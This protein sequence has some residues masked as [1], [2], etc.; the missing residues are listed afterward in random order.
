MRINQILLFFTVLPFV[1]IAQVSPPTIN[2]CDGN[3][4]ICL[5]MATHNLCVNLT[6]Q[7]GSPAINYF[8][9]DWGDGSTI[10][11]VPGSQT[12]ADQ[13]HPYNLINFYNKCD[14]EEKFTVEL[15]T[16]YV[17]DP[18]P[19]NNSFVVRF[20]NKPLPNF[21]YD[22]P[23]CRNVDI[24]INNTTCENA[25]TATYAWTF[26]DGT[27]STL[28][29]PPKSYS[30]TGTY[31]VQLCATNECGTNCITQT[32]MV[33]DR[34]NISNLT[35]TPQNGCVPF[36]SKFTANATGIS[37]NGYEWKV[38]S[39]PNNCTSCAQFIPATG[40]DSIMPIIRF[41]EPGP[42]IVQLIGT[43]SCGDDTVTITINAA[44]LPN[45]IFDPISAGC[46]SLTVN[47]DNQFIEYQGTI[48]SYQWTFPAG[49]SMAMSN[50]ATPG[51][52]IFTQSGTI[53]LELR[54]PCDTIFKTIP[55][56][57]NSQTAVSFSPIPTSICVS[58]PAFNLQATPLGGSFSGTGIINAATGLF[59]PAIAGVGPD[60]IIYKQGVPGCESQGS[61]IITIL[62]ADVVTIGGNIAVC[63]DEPPLILTANP[64]PGMWSG[65]GVSGNQFNPA[66]A[67]IG[68]NTI[69]YKYT[70][71]TG[72]VTNV[73]RVITVVAKPIITA[74][75]TIYTCK[76]N[77][78]VNLA[79]LG[80]IGFT[81][82]LPFAGSSVIWSGLGVTPTGQFTSPGV[83]NY[84]LMVNYTIPPLCDT[85]RTIIVKVADFV[86]AA[87]GKDT[88]LCSSSGTY[89]LGGQPAGGTW[90][91]A[92]GIVVSNPVMLTP[93]NYTFTYTIQQGTP[94][95]SRD[96][97]AITVVGGNAVNA[98]TDR[99][100]C[101]TA[102]TLTLP[103][104][105]GLNWTGPSLNG[106]TIDI[107][108]LNPG[109]YG[110]TLTD[111]S[112]PAGCNTDM[113][114][115]TVAMQPSG[116]FTT[117][118]TACVGQT[119]T[120]LP[121]ATANVQYQINWGDG[122][123]IGSA[124]TH[125]YN[126]AGPYTITF[127]VNTFQGA[128][129][130]CTNSSTAPIY[131]FPPPQAFDFS[132]STNEGC[133]PLSVNFTNSSIVEGGTFFWDF[134]NGQTYIG[135]SPGTIIFEQGIEDTTYQVRCVLKTRCDS[136]VLVKTV[137]VRP[138]PRAG[139]GFTYPFPCS[140][141]FIE[142]NLTSVG[143]PDT[144]T[145]RT[146]EGHVIPAKLGQPYFLQ[147]FTDSLPKTV[148]IWVI[149]ENFC[150]IDTAYQEVIVQPANVVALI[151]LNQ[152]ST[153]I[154]P[155]TYL[156]LKSYST[157]GAVLNWKDLTTG[158]IFV[159]DSVVLNYAQPGVYQVVL[160]AEGCGYDSILVKIRV[161]TPPDVAITSSPVGCPGTPIPF[162][163]TSLAGTLTYLPDST[164]TLLKNF[165]QAFNLASGTY[166]VSV[167]AT[168]QYGC[169]NTAQTQFYLAAKPEAVILPI[170]P[171]C[172]GETF[173][174]TQNS[175]GAVTYVWQLDG[176]SFDGPQFSTEIAQS[177][178]YP[179]VLIAKS[180]EGCPDT[181]LG[182]VNILKT[183]TAI[184]A[185]SIL[186]KC[187]PSQVLVTNQSLDFTDFEWRFSDNTT[188][189]A[190][191][192]IKTFANG[193]MVRMELW[194]SNEGRCF[195]STAIVLDLPQTP[196]A[197]LNMTRHCTV[198]S[199]FTL[200]I[201]H[202]LSAGHT[203]TLFGADTTWFNDYLVTR[204]QPGSYDLSITKA[205]CTNDTTLF[206]PA[207]AELKIGLPADT[208][209]LLGQSLLIETTVN[210]PDL[211]FRWTPELDLDDPTIQNPT[212]SPKTDRL[213][214]ISATNSLGC[215]KTDSILINILV[216]YDSLVY[217]PNAFTP[218]DQNGFNDVFGLRSLN[219]A[220][221][222]IQEFAIYDLHGTQIFHAQNCK[223]A[224]SRFDCEW[225]GTFRGNKAEAGVYKVFIA[226][227]FSDG[228]VQYLERELLLIR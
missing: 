154:C 98:G 147:F 35:A 134:G 197:W 184:F 44:A 15:L 152:D 21:T 140:G 175:I 210:Q 78:P 167:V 49:A 7:P 65:T 96:T 79:T 135:P 151:N 172:A 196:I 190:P 74:P 45:A 162:T 73:S 117:A 187:S 76:I 214:V 53:I 107:A 137:L 164:T 81:P 102:A 200:R 4:I 211:D 146:T 166:A 132:L 138:K 75:D 89:N 128:T 118:D 55:I 32:V 6:V 120:L 11:T 204:L 179:L 38:I 72:C 80:N 108:A 25:P 159:G 113:L 127:T 163:V 157:P 181:A 3:Q 71:G 106:N 22:N 91:N 205:G 206:V 20:R 30:T 28:E 144:N 27:T 23:A 41:T 64:E 198:D 24:D 180:S 178:Q 161:R 169:T 104:T 201:L 208:T 88:T 185:D 101:E 202:P 153:V 39:S 212:A 173:T 121:V 29:N 123:P 193:G 145:I 194:V 87:A 223:P 2:V 174:V 176:R 84:E 46:N 99:F 111:P 199:G 168:D 119:V 136:M 182:L 56:V 203:I 42:Y 86:A 93:G 62:P 12:P 51:T 34:P 142:L 149:T 8:E 52:V 225:D 220:V 192:L 67:N 14:S 97:V 224:V 216:D 18:V 148:G 60:T 226:I 1:G 110:Y 155:N 112:L 48:T 143:N 43:N 219:E 5:S 68:P 116:Q 177:G 82:N 228:Y 33:I 218:G 158:E 69:S 150:G 58:S 160:K 207:I 222:E 59:D 95:Q 165:S 130:L 17:G 57:V 85:T 94:C 115:V 141:N 70:S 188:A 122:T 189:Q 191:Q 50:S 105:S 16:Y 77:T 90:R 103:A 215:T 26:G 227:E 171:A 133:G 126:A 125:V 139:F 186:V 217:L 63:R 170:E 36:T 156:V 221:V 54:G 100:I 10:T 37:L 47:F 83:G 129:L 19:K 61:I 114:N 40:K 9:I 124:L 183:P 31:T 213:Y 209:L 13:Q 66:T 131:I 109:M 92:A 195:D